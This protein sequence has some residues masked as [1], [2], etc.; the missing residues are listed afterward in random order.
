[1]TDSERVIILQT[2]LRKACK[3]LRDNPPGD[4]GAYPDGLI[5]QALIGGADDPEGMRYVNYFLK[6]ALKEIGKE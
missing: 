2:A 3:L 5:E 4:L 6:Q 1:M